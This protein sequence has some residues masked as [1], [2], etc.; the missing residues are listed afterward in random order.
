M[1][2]RLTMTGAKEIRA[3]ARQASRALDMGHTAVL[4][5]LGD[6]CRQGERQ[7]FRTYGSAIGARWA[8]LKDSTAKARMRLARRFGL[9][10][11][12]RD[13][14]LVNFGDLRAALTEEGGAHHVRIEGRVLRIEVDQT[15]INRHNRETGV[16]LKIT[17]KGKRYKIR[18]SKGHYPPN[19]IDI[20]ED[21]LGNAPP[22]KIVGV[23]PP[24]KRR[25]DARVKKYLDGIASILAGAGPMRGR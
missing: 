9:S 16:E 23:P 17:K 12:P 20:H 15:Q 18:G 7:I 8:P 5:D 2:S 1:A 21:G 19:I 24:V 10:I 11:G 14:R 13:P 25:M 4:Q 22:R 6:L 3:Q